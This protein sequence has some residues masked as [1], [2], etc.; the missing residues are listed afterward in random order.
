MGITLEPLQVGPFSG[1]LNTLVDPGAL[2][3]DAGVAVV[4]VDLSAKTLRALKGPGT[5]FNAGPASPTLGAVDANFKWIFLP[6]NNTWIASAWRNHGCLD[7]QDVGYC[8][9]IDSTGTPR[10]ARALYNPPS[11][12]GGLPLGYQS[13]PLGLVAPAGGLAVTNAAG[14]P[15]AYAQTN[16]TWD[17]IESNPYPLLGSAT[18]VQTTGCNGAVLT[19]IPAVGDARWARRRIYATMPN[20][21]A[22]TKYFLVEI[23]DAAATLTWT[24]LAYAVVQ[25]LPLNWSPGGEVDSDTIT[26]DHSPWPEA[27][28]LANVLHGAAPG[29]GGG[30][31]APSSGILFGTDETGFIGRWSRVGYPQYCPTANKFRFPEQVQ[32]IVSQGFETLYFLPSS[33]WSFTG[34]AD[35]SI[36]RTKTGA[37]QGCK[38][39]CGHTVQRTPWGVVYQ[40]LD[41][42]RLYAG[43]TSHNLTQD[44]LDPKQLNALVDTH[45]EYH[46]GFYFLYHSLGTYVFDLR[47]FPNLRITTSDKIVR[48]A[49]V[50]HYD[51]PSAGPGHYVAVSGDGNL[52]R[53]WNLAEIVAGSA[54]LA[55]TWQTPKLSWGAP[56]RLKQSPRFHFDGAGALRFDFYK[57]DA[58]APFYSKALADASKLRQ[59][60]L[61]R[62]FFKYLTVKITSADG[63]GV[64]SNFQPEG[65]TC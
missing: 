25:S 44:L 4:N 24:D 54:S 41:G 53:P 46:E 31:G 13:Y 17:G 3:P 19:L 35:Y 16:V 1:G 22:G 40:A 55:W 49:H 51:F 63:S 36:V 29:A 37:D 14:Q 2:A 26:D 12:F 64:L 38:D 7:T 43:G 9:D 34:E 6:S 60:P 61:P 33:I 39:G 62:V 47:D 32:A 50:N 18:T 45:G 28:V 48:G 57:D 21:P 42:L 11:A 65:V 27:L 8:T 58:A 30:A 59:F 52:F 10:T 5:A 56:D 23:G 15:R 20:D